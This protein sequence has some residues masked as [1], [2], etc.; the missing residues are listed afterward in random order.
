MY[1]LYW[2]N[3][4]IKDN[5]G[6][7]IPCILSP[8]CPLNNNS[9]IYTHYVFSMGIVYPN[10]DI[11]KNKYT[12]FIWEFEDR[13]IKEIDYYIKNI[14]DSKNLEFIINP[15]ISFSVQDSYTNNYIEICKKIPKNFT[16]FSKNKNNN[17]YLEDLKNKITL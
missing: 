8:K 12:I 15:N 17:L 1:P 11:N 6:I 13:Y 16:L 10:K 9:G 2:S 14:L 7:S 4:Y 3:N 5:S